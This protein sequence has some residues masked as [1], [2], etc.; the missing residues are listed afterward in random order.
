MLDRAPAPTWQG[1]AGVSCRGML[2]QLRT[3]ARPLGAGSFGNADVLRLRPIAMAPE[4]TAQSLVVVGARMPLLR[5][6]IDQSVSLGCCNRV[7]RSAS[8]PA[9]LMA[10]GAR[11]RP[12]ERSPE[13]SRPALGLILQWLAPRITQIQRRRSAEP[14][15]RAAAGR[16]HSSRAIVPGCPEPMIPMATEQLV[17]DAVSRLH[18]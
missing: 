6:D 9:R 2:A 10:S 1:S 11:A 4:T 5:F 18:A 15:D 17:T 3:R 8:R 16:W 7:I 14:C 13:G 12:H